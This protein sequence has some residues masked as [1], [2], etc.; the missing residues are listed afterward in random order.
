[1]QTRTSVT[2]AD[3][4]ACGTI[5][6]RIGKTQAERLT[7]VARVAGSTRAYVCCAGAC[8]LARSAIQTR[9]VIACIDWIS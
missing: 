7:A 2:V 4:L 9:I 3:R 6:A 5:Q 1:L 8:G